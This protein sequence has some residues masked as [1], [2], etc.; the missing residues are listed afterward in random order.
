MEKIIIIAPHADDELIGCY[1]ILLSGSVSEVLYEGA[2]A[3]KEAQQ[4]AEHFKFTP[5][6]LS[7]GVLYKRMKQGYRFFFP[8]PYFE[9][10]PVHRSIGSIGEFFL[11][12]GEDVTFYNTT[13]TAP[14]I[15]ELKNTKKMEM[16]NLL[17]FDKGNLWKYEHKYFLFEG[18]T[19][20]IMPATK[21]TRKEK[22]NHE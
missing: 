19:K 8:D 12:E 16:L 6:Q 17:Y 2:K 18:Y 21:P 20:W 15:F 9:T 4:C 1:S 10:H 3:V 13:M 11:R 14:Y 5:I 22:P 7:Q